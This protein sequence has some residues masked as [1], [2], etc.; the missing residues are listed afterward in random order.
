MIREGK[1]TAV[2][3]RSRAA[4]GSASETDTPVAGFLVTKSSAEVERLGDR[5]AGLGGERVVG[6]VA[7]RDVTVELE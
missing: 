5:L 4:R 7:G 6:S 2:T 1:E 3:A